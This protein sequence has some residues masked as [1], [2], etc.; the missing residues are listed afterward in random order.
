MVCWLTPIAWGAAISESGL[1]QAQ[2]TTARSPSLISGDDAT[3]QEGLTSAGADRSL[4]P[5]T[6][7][8]PKHSLSP[9]RLPKTLKERFRQYGRAGGRARASSLA[10]A[11]RT[12]I[13]RR[14]AL[15]RWTRAR[16]GDPS[17]AALGLPGGEL[18]DAG[19]A[20]LASQ[21][22][23]AESLLI[24]LAAPR[25]RREGVPVPSEIHRDPEWRLYQLLE[26]MAGELAHARY[27][28]Y[29]RQVSSFADACRKAR[30]H[31]GR[32]AK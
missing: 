2:C 31:R 22:V 25:L 29:L 28:A 19:L 18:V 8:P 5:L 30:R 7:L 32:H 24:S 13:A 12:S 14:A 6:C 1:G 11:A 21:V 4:G 27:L 20:D 10:P 23:T 3:R 9:M 15:Q 17:F 26:R 16:F